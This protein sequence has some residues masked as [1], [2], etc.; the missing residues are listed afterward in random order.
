MAVWS[1]KIVPGAH[2]GDPAKFVPQNQQPAPDGTYPNGLYA[3]PGD[4]VSWNNA[5]TVNHQ[6]VQ[7][8][9]PAPNTPPSPVAFPIGA[10]LWPAVTPGHQTAAY[11][12]TGNAG[13]TVN[14]FCL[15][16]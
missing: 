7:M 5:T 6:I 4:A 14:Y 15:I 1:I 8:P 2:P 12:V 10:L 13:T 9:P 11:I 3:D 16:H